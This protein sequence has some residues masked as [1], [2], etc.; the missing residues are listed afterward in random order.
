M[1]RLVVAIS[2]LYFLIP[3]SKGQDMKTLFTNIPDTHIPQLETAWRKDL[4]DLFLSGKEALLQ[5]TMNGSSK[6]LNLTEDYLQLQATE[7]TTIEIKRLPLIN[8]TYIICMAT[9]LEGPAPDS[10]IQFFTTDWQPL[11]ANGLFTPVPTSWFIKEG[12]DTESNAF[13]DAMSSLDMDLI[14]YTLSPD[15]Q[16]LTAT[17]TTPLYLSRDERAKVTAYL[18]DTPKVYVWEKSFFSR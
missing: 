9:T 13:K 6:L 15:N 18:K 12:V 5:N 7:R 2:L 17:Y 3:A 8:N 16:N 11:E 1:K 10:R 14:Q 4:I